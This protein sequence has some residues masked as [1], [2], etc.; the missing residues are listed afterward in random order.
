MSN[1]YDSTRG[2]VTDR[3]RRRK[4][5]LETYAAD[6]V[7]AIPARFK[8]E[9]PIQRR[10]IEQYRQDGDTIVE[11][12]RCYRCGRLLTLET[13]T[14][15]RI[16]PGCKGGTYRRSNI[17]PSC[18]KCANETGVILSAETRKTLPVVRPRV[19]EL[20]ARD[21]QTVGRS[22]GPVPVSDVQASGAGG[23]RRD[24][25]VEQ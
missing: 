23:L 5:L 25:S 6:V 11:C 1:A 19:R 4:W 16:I 8:V 20:A 2:N 9:I 17:R 13:L 21:S 7:L 15:D 3:D 12:C 24:G 22:E 10:L 14:V 18:S